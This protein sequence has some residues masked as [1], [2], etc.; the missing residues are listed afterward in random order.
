MNVH[1]I[2]VYYYENP[3][4]QQRQQNIDF[5]LLVHEVK[6]IINQIFHHQRFFS[7]LTLPP[8]ELLQYV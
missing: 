1:K 6:S 4:V 5:Q 8:N 3:L 7:L 2:L